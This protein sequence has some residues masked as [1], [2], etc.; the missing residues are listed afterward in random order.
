MIFIVYTTLPSFLL[1]LYST[2]VYI[3]PLVT[4]LL[5]SLSWLYSNG[6]QLEFFFHLMLVHVRR[7]KYQIGSQVECIKCLE[8]IILQ[9]EDLVSLCFSLNFTDISILNFELTA[10]GT[11]ATFYL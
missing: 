4:F 9:N 3:L 6:F 11:I 1:P 7:V 5:V 8:F 10:L 2:V